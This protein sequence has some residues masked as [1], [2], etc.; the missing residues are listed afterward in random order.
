MILFPVMMIL[1]FAGLSAWDIKCKKLPTGLI[2]WGFLIAGI[3]IVLMVLGAGPLT[4][5]LH[6]VAEALFGAL[7]GLAMVILSYVSDKI[8]RGDG[9]V[10]MIA[11][12]TGNFH[13]S[14]ILIC[15]ACILVALPGVVLL[16]TGKIRKNT[17]LPFVPF[18][19]ISYL[20]LMLLS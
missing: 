10:I 11:G 13:F 20:I 5:R 18:V 7:P 9:L 12:M 17:S 1:V 16:A 2:I 15:M 4:E 3:R 8:G 6:S 19:T 14:V